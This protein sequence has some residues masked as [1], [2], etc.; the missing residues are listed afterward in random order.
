MNPFSI[1]QIGK[2]L[3]FLDIFLRNRLNLI[4]IHQ[5]QGFASLFELLKYYS[6]QEV[7]KEVDV[8]R[9]TLLILNCISLCLRNDI[10]G[11]DFLN[12]ETG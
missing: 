11:F 12:A 8:D 1:E 6:N 4:I 3:L 9:I 7:S 2:N 10:I 5:I